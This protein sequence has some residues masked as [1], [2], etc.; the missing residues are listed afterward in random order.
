MRSVS[1]L[2]LYSPREGDTQSTS[3]RISHDRSVDNDLSSDEEDDT[4]NDL[5][6]DTLNKNSQGRGGWK[7]L[8]SGEGHRSHPGSPTTPTS[9]Q[10]RSAASI[11]AGK[12]KS[13]NFEKF[14]VKEI[15]VMCI[16]L[17]FVTALT[18]VA[19]HIVFVG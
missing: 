18:A 9:P 17:L 6:M 16:P 14:T 3:P 2:P 1:S 10:G 13:N 15:V 5:E 11:Q 8:G 12:A 4:V 19:L 7:M